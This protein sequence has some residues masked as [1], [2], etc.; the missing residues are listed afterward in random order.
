MRRVKSFDEFVNENLKAIIGSP[1]KY[2]KIKNN[3]KKFQQAKVQKA[4]NDVDFEKKKQKSK[5]ELDAKTKATL[6]A[7]N[8]AKNQALTDKGSAIQDRMKD[9]ATSTPLK[10]VVTIGTTKAKVAAAET[11]LKAAD[12]EETKQLK[13]QIAKLNKQA[14][15][16]VKALKDYASTEKDEKPDEE[17]PVQDT[18]VANDD[19]EGTQEEDP[20]ASKIAQLEKDIAAYNKSIET[21]RASLTKAQSELEQANR[22]KELGRTSD[23]AI[24]KIKK[25]IE[26]SQEDIKELKKKES[27][28]KNAL[29]KLQPKEESV[30]EDRASE[31]EKAIK[32]KAKPKNLVPK[33]SM[34]PSEAE[35]VKEAHAGESMGD[36]FR[37]LMAQHNVQSS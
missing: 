1:I 27:D 35:E 33:A 3:L 26:D 34:P 22:D 32:D 30:S 15:D 25:R 19:E 17:A 5:G 12:A 16:E 31:I 9:L 23:E 4:L 13:V 11:A 21:E 10:K 7:A 14:A 36:K 2:T 20:N 24:Q 8:K 18:E 29:D 28:S 37:R 6:A